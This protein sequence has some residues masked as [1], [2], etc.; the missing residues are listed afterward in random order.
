VVLARLGGTKEAVSTLLTGL[1]STDPETARAVALEVRSKVRDAD[2]KTRKLWLGEVLRV[3]EKMRK[4]P[5]PSPVPI[6]TCL[7]ILGYLEDP[8]TTET[9]LAYARDE[10]APFGVRQEAL[11]ALRF[12]LADD[13]HA[14]AV[15]DAMVAAAEAPDRM[16]AQA[17]LMS[18]AA[19]E[20]PAKHAARVARL[21]AHP[22]PERARIALEKLA[23][24]PGAEVTRALVEVVRTQDRRRGEQAAQALV[25]RPDAPP[26]LAEALLEE[27]DADRCHALRTALRGH[28]RGLGAALRERIVAAAAARAASGEAGWESLVDVAREADGA[29]LAE[30]LREALPRLAKAKKEDRL[31]AVLGLLARSEHGS[32]EDRY[33]LAALELRASRKDTRPAARAEDAALQLL[34]RLSRS[35]GFDVGAALRKDKSLDEEALFFAGFHFAEEGHPLGAELLAEVVRRAPRTKLG[36]A[37]K[38]K[39]ALAERGAG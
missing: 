36:K 33:R 29:A 28:A 3:L 27:T 6:A 7:K 14:G 34:G 23:R 20:L 1:E 12:A 18:L 39:L 24:Q 22:D 11:I 26:L 25:A 30:A 10:R 17:A 16:L 13:A 9:L 4:A 19:V 38:N 31:R 21:C 37:A 35:A 2:A 32:D 5:P 8:K 15:V